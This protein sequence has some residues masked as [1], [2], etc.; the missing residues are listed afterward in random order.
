MTS[1]KSCSCHSDDSPETIGKPVAEGPLMRSAFRIPGM[2]CPSEEQMIRL[3]LGDMSIVSLEFD[4]PAR[5]LVICHGGEVSDIL[6]RLEPLGYGAELVESS[7]IDPGDL[8]LVSQEDETKTLWILLA[9]NSVMF[10]IEMIAGWLA[11]SAG[12]IADGADMFAD[13]AVYGTALYAVGRDARHKLSAARLAGVLQLTFALWTLI[14]V[15]RR[16]STGSFPEEIAMIGISLMALTANIICLALI[17]RHREGGI[18]MRASYI[19][20][21]NDVLANLGVILAGVMI[22]WTGSPIPDW[23]IGGLIGLLV[24]SG[25]VRILRLR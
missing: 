2:D 15:A 16:V 4:L 6:N 24:L 25:A 5:S 11:D 21:A 20:S 13:A 7:P 12:L 8:Q 3:R 22:A 18:H 14:E 17:S 23:V 1:T 9:I 10:V 19:F